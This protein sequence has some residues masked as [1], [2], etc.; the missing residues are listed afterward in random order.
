MRRVLP[1]VFAVSVLVAVAAP[2]LAQCPSVDQAAVGYWLSPQVSHLPNGN[3]KVSWTAP[4]EDGRGWSY[5]VFRSTGDGRWLPVGAAMKTY[6]IFD[7]D[8]L[9][10]RRRNRLGLVFPVVHGKNGLRGWLRRH[11]YERCNGGPWSRHPY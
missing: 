3:W 9:H 6:Y 10:L 8:L 7:E 2:V 4:Q 1:V 11:E 5:L